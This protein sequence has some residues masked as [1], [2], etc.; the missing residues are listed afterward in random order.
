VQQNFILPDSF[1]KQNC[2]FITKETASKLLKS[3]SVTESFGFEKDANQN[4]RKATINFR[5]LPTKSKF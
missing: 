2:I 1:L 3:S 4:K 5:W